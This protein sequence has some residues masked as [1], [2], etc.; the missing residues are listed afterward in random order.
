MFIVIV[1]VAS[2]WV[3][4]WLLPDK[5]RIR[6][7]LPKQVLLCK[8]L[9]NYIINSNKAKRQINRIKSKINKKDATK[10]LYGL[11]NKYVTHCYNTRERYIVCKRK[12]HGDGDGEKGNKKNIFIII[13]HIVLYSLYIHK[14]NGLKFIMGNLF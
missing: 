10:N 5:F 2:L 13:Q 6:K 12:K 11:T 4:C 8:Y 14:M 9:A 3:E 1:I 7:L